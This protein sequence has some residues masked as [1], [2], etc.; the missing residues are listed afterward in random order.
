MAN[1]GMWDIVRGNATIPNPQKGMKVQVTLRVNRELPWVGDSN[2]W[3]RH[4]GNGTLGEPILGNG[5]TAF[6]VK[7]DDGAVGAYWL[8]ELEEVVEAI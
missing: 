6:F 5:D 3:N 7:H 2:L 8:D 4:D 1:R